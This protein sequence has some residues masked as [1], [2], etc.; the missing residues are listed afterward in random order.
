MD[1]FFKTKAKKAGKDPVTIFF[2]ISIFW[3][4]TSRHLLG[5]SQKLETPEQCFNFIQS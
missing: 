5:Q 4:N 1:D 3:L 2:L